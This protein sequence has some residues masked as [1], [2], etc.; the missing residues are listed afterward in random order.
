MCAVENAQTD[1]L[2]TCFHGE[3]C[4]EALLKYV[5][6]IDTIYFHNLSYDIRFLAKFGLVNPIQKGTQMKKADIMYKRKTIHLADSLAL[7]PAALKNFPAM[8]QI[9]GIQK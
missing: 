4:A 3:K 6:N 8:L 2:S 9:E 5:N 1:I 7:I